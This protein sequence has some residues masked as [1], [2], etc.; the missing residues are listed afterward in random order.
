MSD[1]EKVKQL[2]EATGAGF[3]DCNLAIK[4]SGGDLDKAVEILRVKGIS[5]A[6]KKMSRDAKEGVIATSGDE[7]KIS[8]IEINCETDFVAKNDDFVSFAKELSELN[9][10]NSSDLEKLNKSK[11]ANGETVEDSLVALIAKMGEKIT[12]GKAKT[13]SQPGSKN[14][15]YLHTVV[16]DNLSKLSV[17]TSLETSNDSED[18]KAFGKQLSMHIAASNPLAL[19]SDLIDKD[20]LQK[21]QDLVTEEL[22]NSG[23][24]EEIAQKISLGKM[25]KFKEE[26]ALL[27]QAWVMEPKKKVQDII[28]ELNIPDLKINNFLR[29]KIGE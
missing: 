3:K 18:V 21:E 23:K 4:E 15:N 20:L 8:V 5:K 17:I 28:K 27:T 13:F 24:P 26:N 7:N 11:M 9:N 10:Q 19:S 1:I 6:S 16:K 25:N 12:L 2:R 29:I 14:F 22:K